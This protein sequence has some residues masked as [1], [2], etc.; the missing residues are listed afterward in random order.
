MKPA[1]EGVR[2][3]NLFLTLSGCTRY[4]LIKRPVAAHV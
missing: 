2:P 4:S 3:F 1:R